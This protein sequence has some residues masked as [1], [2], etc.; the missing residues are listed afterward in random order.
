MTTE[1]GIVKGCKRFNVYD[2]AYYCFEGI[3]YAQPPLGE[4]RF[5][6]PQ[7]PVPWDGVRDCCLPKDKSVQTDFISGK[8]CGSEDCLYLNVYTNQVSKVFES[9]AGK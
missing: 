5:K 1:Y 2:D 6:A 9:V 7:R 8:S 4:L 3:P